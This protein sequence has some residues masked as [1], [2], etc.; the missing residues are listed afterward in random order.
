MPDFF[1][2]TTVADDGTTITDEE[3]PLAGLISRA[4]LVSYLY[5]HEGSPDGEDAEGEYTMAMAWAVAKEIVGEEDDPDEIV[6]VAILREVM[7][8]Y[9][10]YL[11]TTF[12]VV[13]EGEDDMIV[14][15]CDEI[16]AEFYASLEAKAA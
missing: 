1:P 7:T 6:T 8:N 9:A 10:A 13:I 5:I 12:D 15:N 16:L 4:Q 11:D 2:D 14:M 3:I